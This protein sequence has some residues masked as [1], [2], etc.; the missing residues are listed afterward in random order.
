MKNNKEINFKSER[1]IESLVDLK[2]KNLDYITD[3]TDNNCNVFRQKPKYRKESLMLGNLKPDYIIYSNDRPIAIIEV[4]KSNFLNLNAAL[5]QAKKY[6]N[7]LK[8]R[9]CFA[10][11]GWITKTYDM[12][13]KTEIQFG[14]FKTDE[15]MPL[16]DLDKLNKNSFQKLNSEIITNHNQLI[17]IYKKANNILISNEGIDPGIEALTEFSKIMFLKLYAE[18][19]KSFNNFYIK[20]FNNNRNNW[21][22]DVNSLLL[23]LNNKYC[24]INF[25]EK[26]KIKLESSMHSILMLIK[27]INLQDTETDIKGLAFEYFIHSYSKGTNKL[28]QY[29]TPR[30]IVKTLIKIVNPAINETIYDPFCGTG[31]MLVYCWNHLKYLIKNNNDLEILKN[32]TFFGSDISSSATLAKMN[33]I[34]FGDGHN[35]IKRENTFKKYY[36]IKK[37]NKELPKYDVVVTNFPF[38]QKTEWNTKYPL[39]ESNT[40]GICVQHCLLSLKNKE[41]ARAGIIVPISFLHSDENYYDRKFII[42]NYKLERIVDLHQHAFQPFTLQDTAILYIKNKTKNDN[43]YFIYNYIENDGLSKDSYRRNIT[44]NDLEKIFDTNDSINEKIKYSQLDAKLRFK[45]LIS[46]KKSKIKL[47]DFCL[48]IFQKN[49]FAPNSEKDVNKF[50]QENTDNNYPFLM[51]SDINNNGINTINNNFSRV[52]SQNYI[53]K[54]YVNNEYLF[55]K[56]SV[57]IGSSG[58]GAFKDHRAIWMSNK[59]FVPSSTLTVLVPD[60]NKIDMYLFYY[61]TL[62]IKI[63][64]MSYDR[65]YPGIKPYEIENISLDDI[66]SFAKNNFNEIKTN[67]KNIIKNELNNYKLKNNLFNMMK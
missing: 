7:L 66:Y 40:N 42:D 37:E 63:E 23:K 45:I 41:T 48:K 55:P 52:T 4:K 12:L 38:S 8:C 36:D 53:K 39:P 56:G 44:K 17:K 32:K 27:E 59:K 33:M 5:E 65:G 30:N 15:L 34:L 19:D 6:A 46:S 62:T 49:N 16:A 29:F 14:L 20:L 26:T 9:F 2:L 11:N 13:S 31:G 28:G 50:E 43:D 21:I 67:L 10:T 3:I 64:K 51:M 54:E 58:Q 47:K 60:L 18:I 24:K 61:I 1:D 25:F 22:S 35:N 57:I